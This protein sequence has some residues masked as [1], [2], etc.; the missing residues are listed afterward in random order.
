MKEII[1][2]SLIIAIDFDGTIHD[3]KHPVKGRKMG[4]P[5]NG[6]REALK[7]LKSKGY[8]IIVFCYW[9][10]N[11]R[12]IKTISDWMNYFNLP[13]DDITNIK[14]D[15]KAYIDDRGIRFTNWK[16]VLECI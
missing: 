9:A 5:I 7:I 15:A 8:E 4:E 1:D 13:Y 3:F 10:Y 16:E 14:P 2:T 11:E 12:S 6:A